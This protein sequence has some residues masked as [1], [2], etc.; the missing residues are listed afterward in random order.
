MKRTDADKNAPSKGCLVVFAVI[1]V[2]V[3]IVILVLTI[4]EG[5]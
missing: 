2:T 3:I 1:M 5:L 4:S